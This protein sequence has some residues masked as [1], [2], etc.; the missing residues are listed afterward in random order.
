MKKTQRQEYMKNCLKWVKEAEERNCSRAW[1][2]Q[3]AAKLK[4][5]LD[6]II[7]ELTQMP[8]EQEDKRSVATKMPN[9]M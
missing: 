9:D 5:Y 3:C 1:G 4:E 8:I 6:E 7:C 2:V